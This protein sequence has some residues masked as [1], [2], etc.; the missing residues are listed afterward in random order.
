MA[1]FSSRG[2]GGDWLKPDVT[3]PGAQVLAGMTP[4]PDP[5]APELGP[6]GQLFQAIAGTSMSSPHVA[7]AAAL[8]FAKYPN[9]TPAR[10]SPRS[11]PPP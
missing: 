3:A 8:L 2:P 1:D 11:R 7:G 4:T 10:S 5:D 6:P 9:W